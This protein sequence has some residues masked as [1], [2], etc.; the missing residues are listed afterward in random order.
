MASESLPL[1]RQTW[2][3]RNANRA[4]RFARRSSAAALPAGTAPLSGAPRCCTGHAYRTCAIESRDRGNACKVASSLA[5]GRPLAGADRWSEC[6]EEQFRRSRLWWGCV[7]SSAALPV[8]RARSGLQES[9]GRCLSK[10]RGQ[11]EP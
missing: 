9:G 2:E 6:H 10:C 4:A 1:P 7:L 3:S 11:R 5:H 8:H